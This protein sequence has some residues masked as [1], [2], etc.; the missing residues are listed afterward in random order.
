[1]LGC[2]GDPR[3]I[4]LIGKGQFLM[5]GGGGCQISNGSSV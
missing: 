1:V 3:F 2:G 5:G 4:S